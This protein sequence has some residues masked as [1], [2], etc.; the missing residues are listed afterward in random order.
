M[1]LAS[2]GTN[3]ERNFEIRPTR[4]LSWREVKVFYAA[5][6]GVAL[7][8][9]LG[10]TAMGYWPVLPFAGLEAL[11]LGWAFYAVALD[12]QKREVVRIDERTVAVEKGRRRVEDRWTAMRA[13][14]RVYHLAPP[15][16]WYPTRLLLR[17]HGREIELGRF[18]NEEERRRLACDL[19][20][21]LHG[22]GGTAGSHRA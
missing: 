13:W 16:A 17:S 10:C 1:I 20:R 18:L 2:L 14:T 9:A 15:V 8:I 3:N 22:Q 6:V 19:T 12:G 21:V 11:A 5:I 4:S 7:L